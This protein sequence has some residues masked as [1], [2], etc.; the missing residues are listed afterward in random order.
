MIKKMVLSQLPIRRLVQSRFWV[1][2]VWLLSEIKSHH[3]Q[4]VPASPV[5]E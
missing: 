3:P 4:F 5:M 1:I 2:Q